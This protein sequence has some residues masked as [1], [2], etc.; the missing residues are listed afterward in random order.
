[1]DQ[2]ADRSMS[3]INSY[4]ATV[5]RDR[6]VV[7]WTLGEASGN[8]L[9]F[10]GH[11]YTATWASAPTYGQTGAI[12]DSTTSVD[13]GATAYATGPNSQLIGGTNFADDFSVEFWARWTGTGGPVFSTSS[14][15]YTVGSNTNFFQ[16][17]QWPGRIVCNLANNAAASWSVES[18][19]SSYND[20]T[21]HHVVMTRQGTLWSL[22]ID[23]SLDNT[24]TNTLSGTF[25]AMNRTTIATR[26]GSDGHSDHPTGRLQ[27]IA[28]YTYALPAARVAAHHAA[29]T[30]TKTTDQLGPTIVGNVRTGTTWDSYSPR[31][32]IGNLRGLY[33]YSYTT[34][35]Y[36]FAA[37]DYAATW[38]SADATNGFRVKY[39]AANRMVIDASGAASF[40]GAITSTSGTIGGWTIGST[41]LSTSYVTLDSV[42]L[43]ITNPVGGMWFGSSGS[44]GSLT[45]NVGDS[46]VVM[47]GTANMFLQA[48]SG[49]LSLPTGGGIISGLVSPKGT[50]TINVGSGYYVNGD[51]GIT[52]SCSTG[53]QSLDI[54]VTGGIVTG[55]ACATPKPD[56]ELALLRAMVYDLQS[57]LAALE[58]KEI[59]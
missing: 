49:Y 35:T 1:M 58:S 45:Y 57:R 32:A 12:S 48:T 20:S 52:D 36:G 39:G 55:F 42:G 13:I 22:Y 24:A 6:P 23:G 2:Y 4:R 15:S 7:F 56:S 28:W 37:G 26:I 18:V 9:D 33:D 3:S 8:A 50:G 46:A 43:T 14:A 25:D 53:T 29:E 34:A 47:I 16:C 10:S 21:W 44:Y 19:G 27:N 31:W 11:G 17:Y 51:G 54:N 40:T 38:V 30:Y 59:R 41:S 5:L